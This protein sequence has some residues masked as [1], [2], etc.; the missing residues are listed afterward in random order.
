MLR[1]FVVFIGAAALCAG[2][3]LLF[4]LPRIWPAGAELIGFGCVVEI[5]VFFERRYRGSGA[6]DPNTKWQP[7]GE[8][9]IDPATGKLIEVAYDP[10]TGE[11]D[12]KDT[13]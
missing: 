10:K 9:F 6:D 11:R 3:A 2:V 7:T 1:W 8:K 5:G 12:Y 13:R 4:A